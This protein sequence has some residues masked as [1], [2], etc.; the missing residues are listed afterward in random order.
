M[1]IKKDI[2][3]D[4]VELELTKIQEYKTFNLYQV[5]K[6]VNG[7]EVATYRECYTQKQLD[8]IIKNGNMIGD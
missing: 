8:K 4:L 5:T 7:K 2:S 3:G 6:I 1:K